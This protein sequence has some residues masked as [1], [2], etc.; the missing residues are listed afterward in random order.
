M[1]SAITLK[2]GALTTTRSFADDAQVQ[3]VLLRAFAP[4]DELS[5]QAKL[6]YVMDRI[7]ERILYEAR[8]SRERE[9]QAAAAGTAASEINLT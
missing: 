5:N 4:P 2:V 6:D 7:V 3:S 9:L 8:R 1:A